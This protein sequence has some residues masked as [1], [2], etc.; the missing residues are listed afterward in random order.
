M[1]AVIKP[2]IISSYEYP[3][4]PIYRSTFPSGATRNHAALTAIHENTSVTRHVKRCALLNLLF[5][6]VN[7][8]SIKLSKNI[9]YWVKDD[10]LWIKIS[11]HQLCNI[12]SFKIANR[13][14]FASNLTWHLYIYVF[15]FIIYWTIKKV[16]ESWSNNSLGLQLVSGSVRPQ[17][18]IIRMVE[19]FLQSLTFMV[20]ILFFFHIII[21]LSTWIRNSSN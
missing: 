12:V 1:I 3:L 9:K 21:Y 18:S 2:I 19:Y 17:G 13:L 20:F 16:K 8:R 10:K 4:N 11:L 14:I 5:I 7:K 15:F 6:Y